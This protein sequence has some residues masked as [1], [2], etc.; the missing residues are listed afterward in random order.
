MW[1]AK[2]ASA[3]RAAPYIAGSIAGLGSQYVIGLKAVNCAS[4]EILA[5][6]QVTAA[7]KE[8]VLDSLGE[9]TSKLRSELGE[10]LAS[11][12]KF[13]VPLEQ[14]TTTSLE[15]LKAYCLADKTASSK[16]PARRCLIFKRP[17]ELDPNFASAFMG[18]GV[19][20]SNLGQPARAQEYLTK[21]YEL[22]EHASE[23]EKLHITGLYYNVATGEFSK[24][25]A[26]F[27]EWTTNF[28][29]DPVGFIDLSSAYF[30]LGEHEKALAAC[31]EAERLDPEDVI[32]VENTDAGL[33]RPGPLR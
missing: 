30:G 8:K 10:S 17:R 23:Q 27:Q 13:D 16:A 14:A 9:A 31:L 20:Y 2:S 4:G 1:P 6:E 12:Q 26:T 32:A 33:H 29:R 21:A 28:P 24:A 18:V 25:M 22:R 19:M 11:V 15:A 7:G 5:Q 3:P